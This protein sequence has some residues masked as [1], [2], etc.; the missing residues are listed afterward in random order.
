MNI[1]TADCVNACSVG[2][3][4]EHVV[5]FIHI[6]FDSDLLRLMLQHSNGCYPLIRWGFGL[7]TF[8]FT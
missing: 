1:S 5:D 6:S 8:N 7:G 3:V 2:L 4:T